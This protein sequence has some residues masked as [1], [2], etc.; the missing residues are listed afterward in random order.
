M[1]DECIMKGNKARLNTFCPI[2]LLPAGGMH[3]SWSESFEYLLSE[4]RQKS[5]I[6]VLEVYSARSAK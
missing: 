2:V 4:K 5:I 1:A 6:R 3:K